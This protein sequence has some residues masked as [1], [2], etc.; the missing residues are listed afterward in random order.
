MRFLRALLDDDADVTDCGVCDNCT[1][2]SRTLDLDRSLVRDAFRFLRRRRFTIDPKKRWMR[3]PQK[4]IP[5][6]LQNAAG[7]TLGI[8]GD[9]G[10]GSEVKIAKAKEQ[11]HFSDDLVAAAAEAIGEAGLEHAP[12]WVTCVPSSAGDHVA[13]F[14]S[15]L[16]EALGLP[17]HQVVSRAR[18]AAPQR[19]M[20]NSFQ[21]LRNVSGAFRVSGD[22]PS[23]PVLLVDDTVDSGWTLTV[24]GVELREAGA[25]PVTPFALAKAT[26]D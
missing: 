14:A 5:A 15:R 12:Q 23:G 16:A 7:L 1:G 4:A 9:G 11:P 8:Y 24:V 22:V 10:W 26:S 13:N 17:F 20:E 6:D 2:E 3:S 18:A 21:Q 19:E 25:G